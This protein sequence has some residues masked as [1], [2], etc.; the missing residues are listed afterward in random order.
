MLPRHSL[1]LHHLQEEEDVHLR[2]HQASDPA[3]FSY[4]SPAFIMFR[5]VHGLFCLLG[6]WFAHNAAAFVFPV[7]PSAA[8]VTSTV[9]PAVSLEVRWSVQVAR[10]ALRP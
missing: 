3:P 4:L 5:H 8:R 10:D 7:A 9:R 1:R 6:L 2:L